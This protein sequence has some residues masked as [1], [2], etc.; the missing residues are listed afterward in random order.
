MASSST[1]TT[2]PTSPLVRKGLWVEVRNSESGDR[3]I[4]IYAAPIPQ[5]RADRER[6]LNRS[7]PRIFPGAK[8]RTYAGGTAK[9][10]RGPLL[11]AA[12]YGAV[13]D[14]M[15]LV[16]LEALPQEPT[17]EYVGQGTLFAL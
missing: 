16:P 4:S 6:F 11:I 9:F 12:H 5:S 8:L 17:V 15:E 10:V 3:T 2:E 1:A 13:R 14:D 7:I